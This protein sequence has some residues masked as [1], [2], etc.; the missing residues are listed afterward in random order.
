MTETPPTVLSRICPTAGWTPDIVP[1]EA[2]WWADCLVHAVALDRF[3]R[4]RRVTR[5]SGAMGRLVGE[6]REGLAR[7]VDLIFVRPIAAQGEAAGALASEMVEADGVTE[8]WKA[9]V[10]ASFG[11]AAVMGL[12]G[13][14]GF[15]VF[16]DLPVHH[17]KLWRLGLR[18]V[19]PE[20]ADQRQALVDSCGVGAPDFLDLVAARYV[21]R[22][23]GAHG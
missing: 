20:E 7:D 5:L 9:G 3:Y 6:A 15:D 2:R 11:L 16:G 4:N 22:V 17:H 23:G 18:V 1:P 14:P 21:E 8:W 12:P 13:V 19:T 10:Q